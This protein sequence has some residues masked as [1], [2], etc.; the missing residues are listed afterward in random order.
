MISVTTQKGVI[1]VNVS[2]QEIRKLFN[3]AYGWRLKMI[4]KAQEIGIKPAAREFGT[5]HQTVRYWL[6]RFKTEG[7]DGLLDK[8][9]KPKSSP[10]KIPI[11]DEEKIVALRKRRKNRISCWAIKTALKL[12]YSTSTIYR[13]LKDHGLV[14]KRKR[15]YQ[16][17][18]NLREI[19]YRLR[20]F[21]KIQVDV[22]YLD[23]ISNYYA[24]YIR[25]R[26]PRFE[27]TARDEKTGAVF[28]SFAHENTNV[29]AA[30]FITYVLEHLQRHNITVSEITVQS[31][32][33]LEFVGPWSAKSVSL[34]TQMVQQA[35]GATH[36]RIPRGKPNVNA[37]VES[38]HNIVEHHFFDLEKYADKID[39]LNKA[40]TYQLV[41]NLMRPN[42]YRQGKTPLK[43][44]NE[45]NCQID[46]AVLSLPPIILDYHNLL[47]LRKLN[48]NIDVDRHQKATSGVYHL[49]DSPDP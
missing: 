19:K 28:I 49:P 30:S 13:V 20:P 1:P 38:F 26:F 48:S 25:E 23:D 14:G 10:L 27:F 7:L 31:D 33:G 9:R 12:T 22:K 45:S 16:Q 35:Y 43:T 46:P 6:S 34:F 40:Y 15:K 41:F 18:R 36:I 5:T 44:L 47:Y 21:E 17:K 24:Y 11:E 37:D 4:T 29:N 42:S 3:N 2:Y 32:N 8:S 39:F